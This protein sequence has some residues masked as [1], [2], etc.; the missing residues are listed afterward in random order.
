MPD[1]ILNIK[2]AQKAHEVLKGRAKKRGCSKRFLAREILEA[3]L[4][5]PKEQR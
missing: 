4:I 2:L 5:P 3:D 1:K